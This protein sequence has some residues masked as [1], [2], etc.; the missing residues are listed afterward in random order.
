MNRP[1]T[2]SP[3]TDSKTKELATFVCCEANVRVSLK[4]LCS[5]HNTTILLDLLG[6]KCTAGGGPFQLVPLV[7]SRFDQRV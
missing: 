6:E 5:V 4:L 2:F 7:L 3:F 1:A